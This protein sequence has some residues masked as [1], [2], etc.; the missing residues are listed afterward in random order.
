MTTKCWE[1]DKKLSEKDHKEDRL[2]HKKCH[3]RI[4]N[5][6]FSEQKRIGLTNSN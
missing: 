1:C 3:E 2:V 6:V 5:E 4:M